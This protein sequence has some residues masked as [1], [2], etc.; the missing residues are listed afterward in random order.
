MVLV[1]IIKNFEIQNLKF[2][3]YGILTWTLF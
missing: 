1:I 2:S 3:S